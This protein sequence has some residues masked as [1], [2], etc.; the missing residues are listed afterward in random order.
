MGDSIGV[1]ACAALLTSYGS[2]WSSFI[3]MWKPAG[4]SDPA[5]PTYAEAGQHL[6]LIREPGRWRLVV[7][8]WCTEG[9]VTDHGATSFANRLCCVSS[10]PNLHL[11]S[12]KACRGIPEV[13]DQPPYAHAATKSEGRRRKIAG[14]GE[15]GEGPCLSGRRPAA[16]R[17]LQSTPPTPSSCGRRRWYFPQALRLQPPP[18]PCLSKATAHLD[19]FRCASLTMLHES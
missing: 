7:L 8:M 17:L 19:R 12:S 16:A 15:V 18:R 5:G 14:C 10:V 6:R 3:G 11:Y 2:L 4:T 13:G 1:N 9:P